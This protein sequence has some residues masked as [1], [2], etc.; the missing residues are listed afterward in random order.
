MR[1]EWDPNQVSKLKI[2]IEDI[3]NFRTKFDFNPNPNI[4][5]D[6]PLKPEPDLKD[7]KLIVSR[8]TPIV[9]FLV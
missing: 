5:E 2:E 4:I 9:D 8:L 7:I 1:K 6:R 3:S